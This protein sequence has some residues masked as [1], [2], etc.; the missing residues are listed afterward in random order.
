MEKYKLVIFGSDWDVYQVAY[1]ELISNPKV[2]YIETFRPSGVLG[3]MQRI[4]F[5]PRLNRLLNMP[6]KSCWNNYYIRQIGKGRVCFLILENW[7]RMECGIR[8]L[9]FLKNKFPEAKIVCFTQD[10][11][12]TI[13]DHYSRH[14]IDVNYIKRYADLFIS[15]DTS[16]AEKYSIDYH[17]TVFSPVS[18]KVLNSETVAGCDLYFLGRDKGRLDLLVKICREATKRGLKCR[19]LLI[20]VQQEKQIDCEGIEYVTGTVSYLDNLRNCAA[21]RCIV[22]LL[23]A[24]AQSPTFRVWE[25][26]AL[27]RKL[28]TN[29]AAIVSADVYDKRYISVFTNAADLDWNFV[30]ADAL[31]A[32]VRNQLIDKIR[33][34]SLLNFIEDKLNIQI[35]R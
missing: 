1:D 31:P 30:S 18:A 23:Q 2:L 26:I 8:L 24:D 17:P 4:Q 7:L 28:L 34:D 3:L 9:P 11:I 14:S 13:K 6:F 29:N 35:N 21:S 16:D 10:L 22:E 27:K 12:A 33:P 20:D 15:Y 19:F 5:N 32:D 25:A